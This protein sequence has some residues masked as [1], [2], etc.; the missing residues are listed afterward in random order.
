MNG[1]PVVNLGLSLTS[2]RLVAAGPQ[3]PT[4]IREARF[5]CDA[6]GEESVLGAFCY[7]GFTTSPGFEDAVYTTGFEPG[8]L[9]DGHPSVISS[10][11][12][13]NATLAW[14]P[15]PGI[16][17]YIGYSGVSL[18]GEQ[19]AALARLAG[20][21]TILSPAEWSATRP[22]VVTQSTQW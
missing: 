14:E 16:V 11:G 21:A 12:G 10:V 18:G 15:Q 7:T 5:G 20:R 1:R 3:H 8:P 2:F 6:L 19:A 22:Q 4:L 13:G 9:V 17:A